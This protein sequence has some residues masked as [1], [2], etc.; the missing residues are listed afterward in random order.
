[1][2]GKDREIDASGHMARA[3]GKGMPVTHPESPEFVGMMKSRSHASSKINEG[4]EIGNSDVTALRAG[5]KSPW[6]ESVQNGE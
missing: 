4:S 6:E 1:M 3:V 2:G 5:I